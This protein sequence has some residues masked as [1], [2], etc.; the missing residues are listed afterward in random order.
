MG[1]GMSKQQSLYNAMMSVFHGY[2]IQ[3]ACDMWHI[4]SKD[5]LIDYMGDE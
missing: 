1:E 3:Q 5:E 4:V 2:T